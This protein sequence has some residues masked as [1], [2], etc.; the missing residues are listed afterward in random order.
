MLISYSDIIKKY[1]LNIKT[2]LHVGAHIAEEHDVYFNNTCQKVIWVEG[3][4]ELY[5]A[6]K[7]KLD[8]TNN[9]VLH[10]VVSN[11]DDE[12]VDFTITNNKQSSSILN[13]GIHR[14]LFPDIVLESLTTVKTKTL[15]T[16]FLENNLSFKE[17]DFLN[18]DIQ[19][20]ELLALKGIGEELI[21]L[22]AIFT[23][24]NTDYVYEDCALITDIDQYLSN[25]GFKRVETVMWQDH[26]WGD[27]LY[28]K[29]EI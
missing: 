3:N 16:L 26:P 13:L 19:G 6:L 1:N 20:A 7:Q 25:F 15:K 18:L 21:N 11:R 10:A 29:E 4:L 22:K 24:V 12:E 17:I 2:I 14:K 9:I 5:E 28:I 27:A 8:N 23:E